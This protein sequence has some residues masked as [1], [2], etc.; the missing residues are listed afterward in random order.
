M[1]ARV[2]ISVHAFHHA[3]MAHCRERGDEMLVG[4][5]SHMHV[6]EQGGSAQVSASPERSTSLSSIT[7]NLMCVFVC[8]L[9]QL[10]GVYPNVLHTLSDGTFDLDEMESKIRHSYPKSYSTRSRLICLENTHS[11]LGGR[12]LPLSF[13]QEVCSRDRKC[14]VQKCAVWDTLFVDNLPGSTLS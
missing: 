2:I 14:L 6:F 11:I 10:A 3:V 7:L 4:D 5:L 9:E 12:V 1:E 8:L 13:L